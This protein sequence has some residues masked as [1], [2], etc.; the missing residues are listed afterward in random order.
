MQLDTHVRGLLDMLAASGRPKMWE[1]A[2][3][4][5]R[6]MALELTS[7]V[8][9]RGEIGR[10]ENGTLPGPAEPLPYRAYTP[11]SSTA[12]KLPCIVYF[13]GG[14]WVFGYLDTHDGMCRRLANES[15]CCVVSI[16]YRLAPEHK[17]PAA[18]ED[19]YAA[20]KWI[21]ANGEGFGIDSARIVVAVCRRQSSRRC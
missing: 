16:D 17:F 13:H 2:P 6:K 12:E 20:T 21:A 11:V 1:L 7:M 15:S 10:V 14:G 4:D 9:A 5:A 19:A 18:V 8:E 3:A